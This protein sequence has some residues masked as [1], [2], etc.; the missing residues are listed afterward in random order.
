[1]PCLLP[2]RAL[3][4]LQLSV[5]DIK[6]ADHDLVKRPTAGLALLWWLHGKGVISGTPL[7]VAVALLVF[8]PAWLALRALFPALPSVTDMPI[9]QVRA[10]VELI[11]SAPAMRP[12]CSCLRNQFAQTPDRC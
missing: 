4:G 8:V 11:L 7:S 3:T 12:H 2:A 10:V 9:T 6:A 1:V 5:A